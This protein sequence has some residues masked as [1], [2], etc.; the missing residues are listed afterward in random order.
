MR[1]AAVWQRVTL[2]FIRTVKLKQQNR[3]QP[4][5]TFTNCASSWYLIL[6]VCVWVCHQDKMWFWRHLQWQQPQSMF[7]F[8]AQVFIRLWIDFVSWS[9]HKLYRCVVEIKMNSRVL[10]KQRRCKSRR[11]KWRVGHWPLTH[12]TPLAYIRF[13][14]GSFRCVQLRSKLS[15][16]PTN[17]VLM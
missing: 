17:N 9:C 6:F 11:K 1:R 15:A 16:S 8:S 12:F 10:S 3:F 4:S 14:S 13:K 2:H 7:W 5:I